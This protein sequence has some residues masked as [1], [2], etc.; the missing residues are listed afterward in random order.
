MRSS[1]RCRLKVLG[2][3]RRWNATSARTIRFEYRE[4]VTEYTRA[5]WKCA[6]ARSALV[7]QAFQLDL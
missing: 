7:F 2:I 4:M 3:A 6:L 1:G 5:G